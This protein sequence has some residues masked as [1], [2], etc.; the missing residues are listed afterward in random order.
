MLGLD[1]PL[2]S[3][4]SRHTWATSARD[5]N[6]PIAVISSGM[7]HTSERTTQI[8]LAGISDSII[9]RFNHHILDPLNRAVKNM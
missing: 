2:T 6:T 1:T 9:D 8:Y 7:G 3:Y 4:V 5:H